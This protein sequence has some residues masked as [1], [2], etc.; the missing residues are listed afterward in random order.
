M[1]A[2]RVFTITSCVLLLC[3]P[4]AGNEVEVVVPISANSPHVLL[5]LTDERDADDSS[6]FSIPKDEPG[7]SSLPLNAAPNYEVA[8]FDTG[9][10]ATIIG[11]ESFRDF[12]IEA[13]DRDG[14][15]ITELGG[16]GPSIEAVNSDPLGVYAVGFDGILRE[17]PFFVDRTQMKGV[18]S[19]S[20]L[21]APSQD[22]IPNLVGTTISSHY[23]TLIDY[24]NPQIVDLDG[25]TYRS[26]ATTLVDLGSATAPTRRIGMTLVPGQ[27]GTLPAFLPDLANLSLDDLSDNP[28]TPTIAGSFWLTANVTNNGVSRNQLDMIFDTGAQGSFV[29]EQIA[30][31]MGFD[32]VRDKPDFVVR[33]AGVTGVSEEVPGF[34]ADEFALPGTDGGLVLKDVPLIVFN[35]TDPRDG[36][37]TLDGLIGMNLFATRNLTLNPE[38]GR[39][40][41]GVSDPAQPVHAWAATAATATFDS[42]SSWDESGVPEANWY[43][44][45][46]NT[47]GSPQTALVQQDANVA[48]LVTKGHEGEAAGTMTVRI[49]EDKTLTLFGSAIIRD[50]SSVVLDNATLAPLAVEIRGGTVSGTGVVE[51]E[52]LSQGT[53]S[54]A[55]VGATGTLEFTGSLDQLSRGV[56]EIE[57]G[58]IVDGELQF[59]S[60]EVAGNMTLDGQLAIGTTD[61][62]VQPAPG[63]T[64]RITFIRADQLIGEFAEYSFNGVPMEKEFSLASD[65]RAFRDHVGD[66]QFIWITF[67]GQNSVS[68]RNYQALGGDVDG[69]G[70][71]QFNDFLEVATNFGSAA[72]WTQGDLTGDGM[73][74]FDDFLILSTN[75]EEVAFGAEPALSPVP[76]PSGAVLATL[77]VGICSLCRRRRRN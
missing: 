25:E 77:A 42:P 21:Y 3:A 72:D 69:D 39:S 64:D 20:I 37:N 22:A 19:N 7:G 26:P 73:V 47:M 13:A 45:L 52:V 50:G 2:H 62:Y 55:G 74:G 40:Y 44:S 56:L 24:G 18:F 27:L 5:S 28:S 63:E 17:D 4:L 76:E 31:E 29:S 10:P 59:D 38:A 57:F 30:A 11:A 49:E 16:V 46:T 6:F 54:P 61:D 43:T 8:V 41:L 51:G 68:I 48:M 32:V 71:V 36:L 1:I 53:I 14:L 12:G 33:I 75:F 67:L 35:L 58:E 34:Y 9:A 65:Q 23:T 66:G 60:L 70:E 15:N